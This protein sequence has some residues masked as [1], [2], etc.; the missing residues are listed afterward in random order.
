MLKPFTR[1]TLL[2]FSLSLLAACGNGSGSSAP[3][4]DAGG[5]LKSGQFVDN[6]V[7]GLEFSTG[8]QQGLSSR[9]GEYQY[10][11]GE[12]LRLSIGDVV[13][14][15]APASSV[16]TPLDF[17]PNGDINHPVATNIARTL[18][19]LD[20]DC[21]LSNG[22]RITAQ[23]RQAGIGR[24]GDNAVNFDQSPA[25]FSADPAVQSFLAVAKGAC[26]ELIPAQQAREHLQTT[27]DFI[28]ANDGQPNQLPTAIA[29]PDR[30]VNA[31]T[32]VMLNGSTSSDPE[33]GSALDFSW[34]QIS[35]PSVA[36]N[37]ANSAISVFTSPTVSDNTDLAFR[38][39]VTDSAGAT[40]TDEVIITVRA[41]GQENQP[42]QANA[43]D[44]QTVNQ[45]DSVTLD[46]SNS[47]D[48][49]DG[50]NLSFS[51]SQI[52]GPSVTLSNADTATPSFTAPAV[53]ADSVLTFQLVVRDSENL[54]SEP[55]SVNVTVKHVEPG[56]T[57]PVADAGPDR[58]VSEGTVVELDGSAS[59]DPQDRTLSYTWQQ[60]S[61]QPVVALDDANAAIARFTAP[62]VAGDQVLRFRL[63]VM[64]SGNAVATDT[65]QVTIRDTT[66]L[67][68]A[69]ASV[70][71]GDQGNTPMVFTVTL[72]AAQ[73][74]AVT[75]NFTTR[76]GTASATGSPPDYHATSGSLRFEP[77][78]T[79]QTITVNVLG[80][81][82]AQDDRHFFLTLTNIRNTGIARSE[83]IGTIIDDDA[84]P[85][86]VGASKAR[87]TPTDQHIDGIEE[88]RLGGSSHIQRFNLGGFGIDPT[89]NFPDP[90]GAFGDLL[91]SP[92]GDRVY[93]NA[94]EHEEHT[95][96]RAMVVAERQADGSDKHVAFV[97]LDAVG[98]GNVISNNL[99]AAVSAATGIAPDD[100]LFS[101][102]HSHAGADL[103]GLWGGVPQDW[104]DSI[105]YPAAVTAVRDAQR[106]SC[107]AHLTVAQGE[108]RRYNR[109]RRGDTGLNVEADPH[110]TLLQARCASGAEEGQLKASLLQYNAHPVG[111]GTG[112][113]PRVPH[114]DY[115]LG[116]VEWLEDEG[117]VA[118][119]FNGPIAEAS[120]S[121]GR[122]GCAYP[123]D[124]AY[125]TVR[126]RGEGMAES[127]LNFEPQQL[128][129]TLE[130]KH[131]T[132]F[133]PVTNPAFLAAGALGS[134]NRYYDFLM[135]P[136]AD[137][138]FLGA[139]F[140]FLPQITPT[141]QTPV[142]RITIGGPGGLE[143]VTIPGEATNTFGQ[144]IRG[145]ADQSNPGAT[146]MLLGLTQQSFGYIIPENEFLIGEVLVFNDP[147]EEIVSLGPLTA[148]MLRLQGYNPLFD[149]PPTS[150][151]NLPLWLAACANTDDPACIINEIGQR[152]VH[153]QGLYEASCLDI[154]IPEQFCGLFNPDTP[155]AQPCLDAGF[156][157]A[158]CSL[159]G[160]V[161]DGG[162]DTGVVNASCENG[163][164][165]DGGRS[166]QVLLNSD[167]G[168]R[169]SFE[170][171]EPTLID[172]GTVA[173]GAHPLVL[174]SHGFGGSRSTSGFGSLRDAGFTVISI[175]QRGFGDSSGTVRVMDPEFEGRDLVQILDWA[176]QN[177]DYLAWRDRG[178]LD[179]PF[180]ARPV[181]AESTPHGENLVVGAIGGSYGG[182]Y[183]LLLLAVDEKNR[184]DAIVPDIA[185]HDLRYSLNPNDTIK[186]G[187]DLLLVAGGEAGSLAPGLANQDLPLD[188]GL[189]PFIRETLVRGLA[190]NE[191]P[192]DSLT[193]FNYHS[194]G[195]WCANQG[196]PAMP[197]SAAEWSPLDANQTVTGLLV[198]GDIPAIG[199]VNRVLPPVD[200]LLTQGMRDTLFNF[201]DA[202]WNFQCLSALGGDVHLYT[203]QSG[204]ILPA[205]QDGG[206]PQAC[207]NT[208]LSS[209]GNVIV[210]W[211]RHKLQGAG[212]SPVTDD[213][214]L[215]LGPDDDVRMPAQELLAPLAN[216]DGYTRFD[217][218]TAAVPNG[219]IAQA[220]FLD[221]PTVVEL[222]EVT[223]GS[224][225]LLAGI[226]RAQLNVASIPGLQDVA[227]DAFV[228]P[229]LRTS[230]D[231]ILFAG[232]GVQPAGSNEWQLIDE[233]I[234]PLRGLGTHEIDMVG[235]AERLAPGDRVALLLYGYHPQYLAS[236]SRDPSLPFVQV[237]GHVD[238]PLYG[239]DGNTPSAEAASQAVDPFI[240]APGL[241]LCVPLLDSCLSD[242]PLL[243]DGLQAVL[244]GISSVQLTTRFIDTCRDND[245]TPDQ[246][247]V[248]KAA[249]TVIQ[250]VASFCRQLST[251]SGDT[252][253][254]EVCSLVSGRDINERVMAA[255][256]RTWGSRAIRL[257]NKLGFDLPMV[258]TQVLATHN[259]FNATEENFPPTLSGLDPNQF[260]GVKDQLR[261]GVRGI[262]LDV[263]WM[264][265]LAGTPETQ[266]RA[267]IVCHGNVNHLGCTIEKPLA[268]EL[269]P[270]RAWLDDNPDA[271]VIID[272]Q[273]EL[274]EEF[275]DVSVSFDTA[276]AVFNDAIG[277]LVFGPSDHNAQCE[278][279]APVSDPTSWLNVTR[280]QMR[281]AGKQVLMYAG[282]CGDG[283]SEAWA[284]L[285]HRKRGSNHTQAAPDSYE[286]YVY[287]TCQ[288]SD[289]RFSAT[290]RDTRWTRFFEDGTLVGA[291]TGS[292]G[293]RMGSALNEF[294]RCGV[295]M[296]SMDFIAPEEGHVDAWI[297]SW[298]P[299]EPP[300][301]S[302][303]DCAYQNANGRFVAADCG[304][305]RPYACVATNDP[306]DWHISSI[307]SS[308]HMA[309][310]PNGYRF[311]VSGSGFFNEALRESKADAGVT[312]VWLNYRRDQ[313]QPEKWLSP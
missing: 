240:E 172:C 80:N 134:F 289:G 161:G 4:P 312:E 158:M 162:V 65:V 248:C 291:V 123:E 204:H 264:P 15:D 169:I 128:A 257:Q 125:G 226:G 181:S 293:L 216:E 26:P 163:Q 193:W 76:D 282:S 124:G 1:M 298:A 179:T 82:I 111:I 19:T 224:G 294:A 147:Y 270:L 7:E 88:E 84:G 159:L 127:G 286:D 283:N 180:V 73:P 304:E 61:G 277:D 105:L 273:D 92:A 32:S 100:I 18:I 43:G 95:W 306:A 259:S 209:S 47:S 77:G 135:L 189:D 25:D 164:N 168:E 17:A 301:T 151:D 176:E 39:T 206:G 245:P 130:T 83:A 232:F 295:N 66:E 137:I 211:L 263:H 166:Y 287:P 48:P 260:Y 56:V 225:A 109:Y 93:E 310:C 178:A 98:A 46:G 175:D 38:L 148:P 149:V 239:F 194:L 81:T 153:I 249:D 31:N 138:P 186:T 146:V 276:A 55:D 265:S 140:Q 230:C 165:V 152:L 35:G 28:A 58:D 21:D 20:A 243:G 70:I 53:D 112:V 208:S 104:I 13:L 64:N 288:A 253:R 5:T 309:S 285:F 313:Q 200:A 74:V 126:C 122:P 8:S 67:S 133:L 108:E 102:T 29:G 250:G 110:L 173:N 229:T 157:I 207:G 34:V 33:D 191:F 85:L 86:F 68:I 62:D 12:T 299:D 107:R 52:A 198:E 60:I 150:L 231:A 69:D 120:T 37:N 44:D 284:S 72:S 97:S 300:V 272:V 9:Q 305:I 94:H 221:G 71:E 233:Q 242:L 78:E 201:N 255:F 79:E 136:T 106:D 212:V 139:Q 113:D 308:W 219:I 241:Q 40:H 87:V 50:S 274:S 290:D 275:D 188:R 171:L 2:M 119:Y 217:I 234:Q 14:G 114:A 89:Q 254:N 160:E 90:I 132:V 281:A 121:G 116:A 42:P 45:G 307:A 278:D 155:L 185:W 99:K 266:F 256:E 199:S 205:I 3:P 238:V 117:G 292:P 184:L 167:S 141:A 296:P 220:L 223:S 202:W 182:G 228:I 154:G 235:V 115:I 177:L 49:E 303:R 57:P 129:P 30:T 183:Q 215:S 41:E 101:Q 143:I 63:T 51:W 279:S 11:E 237:T 22:I 196:L 96:I 262:E 10:R 246:F 36:L 54:S 144:Y 187:W 16:M 174:H 258:H 131:Q 118:M 197:Y 269:Q 261:M 203:H 156:P 236:F 247:A 311:G 24:T 210:G 6:P 271:I 75:L 192:R 280:E 302:G 59:I 218:P 91:T 227:C 170:V 145:L 27:L 213:L 142:S 222:A 267:P 268:E 214:C 190:T 23:A 252:V 244:D 251:L 195:F 103:Q 297:W